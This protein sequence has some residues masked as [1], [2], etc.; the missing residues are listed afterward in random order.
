MKRLL[1]AGVGLVLGHAVLSSGVVRAVGRGVGLGGRPVPATVG[2]QASISGSRFSERPRSFFWATGPAACAASRS[3]CSSA[4][5]AARSASF[6]ALT[7]E[8]VGLG[9]GLL[10]VRAQDHDHVAAVLLGRRLDEAQLGDV[11]GELLQQA[12][13]QLGAVLLATAEHDRD[14]DL[15]AGL[16]EPDDVA[17]L[18]LV[19]VGV[20]LGTKLHLLDDHVRLVA[21]RLTGLLGVLVLELPVVHELADG[22][23][24][25]RG[26]LDEVEVGFLGK[27]QRVGGGHD[28]DGLA[29]LGPTSR[30]SLTRIRS[31]MRSSV[32]MCPPVRSGDGSVTSDA[33]GKT[34][35][36]S[37]GDTSGSQS[38]PPDPASSC[39]VCTSRQ[40]GA[41]D[42]TRRPVPV[43]LER[44][45]MRVGDDRAWSPLV[46][47]RGHGC[48]AQIGQR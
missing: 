8:V 6:S 11:L 46:D 28:A 22:R 12:E 48:G 42:R 13:A 45:S 37:A 1:G 9:L 3:A 16:E 32:L 2:S 4:S 40:A 20:D 43:L 30:T 23:T 24:G 14:L 34:G 41:L 39:M 44:R 29:G 10:L 31:L 18:R 5:W 36:A 38:R 7:H 21:T 17:L 25:H 26:D 27:A 33:L 15:V 47:L 19:V 35:R